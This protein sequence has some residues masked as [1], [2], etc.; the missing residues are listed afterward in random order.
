MLG[1]QVTKVFN[2]SNYK[3]KCQVRNKKSKKNLIQSLNLKNLVKF[4]FF[5]VEKDNIKILDRNIKKKMLL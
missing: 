2:N 5:D 4:F 1:W 3:I